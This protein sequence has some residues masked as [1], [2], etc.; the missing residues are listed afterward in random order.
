MQNSAFFKN[1][2]FSIFRGGKMTAFANPKA[3]F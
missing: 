2:K 3:A 1:A